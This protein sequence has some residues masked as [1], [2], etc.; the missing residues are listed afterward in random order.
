MHRDIKP[1]NLILDADKKL[2]L[3]DFGLARFQS[4]RPITRTGE[5][6]GTMRYMSPEQA[7]GHG[8][9]VDHRTDI[10]SLGAT[11]YEA[12]A[13]EPAITGSEGAGLI[14]NDRTGIA[15]RLRKL[16]AALP[17]DVQT[18]VEKAMAKHRDD[19]YASADLF[20]QD[21]R[22]ASSGYPILASRISPVVR[23]WRWAEKRRMLISAAVV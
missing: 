6:I 4:D 23:I 1:S 16:C 15:V 3:A 9:L 14:A 5:M 7:S 18:L 17:A 11:L 21:L 19:R 2:W 22:R 13:L 12:L 8:E 20:A 10:Y